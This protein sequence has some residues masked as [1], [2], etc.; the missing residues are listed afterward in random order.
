[1]S[2]H[3]R[4]MRATPYSPAMTEASIT[5]IVTMSRRSIGEPAVPT[6]LPWRNHGALEA[7]DAHQMAV[8]TVIAHMAPATPIASPDSSASCRRLSWICRPI[9]IPARAQTQIVAA[10]TTAQTTKATP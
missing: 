2:A 4:P 5:A 8:L 3:D 7:I 10:T 6:G 1:M 9:A